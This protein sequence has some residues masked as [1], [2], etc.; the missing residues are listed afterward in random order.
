MNQKV[1]E[2]D[3]LER[4]DERKYMQK[5][6]D[7]IAGTTKS[8]GPDQADA[9]L[10]IRKEFLRRELTIKLMMRGIQKIEGDVEHLQK[11]NQEL[12]DTVQMQIEYNK[13]LHQEN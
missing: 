4:Q 2:D 13:S 6:E 7:L 3:Q 12:A 1:D 9:I 8:I 5:L 11:E 10:A